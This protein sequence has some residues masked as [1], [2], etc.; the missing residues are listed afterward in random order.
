MTLLARLRATA[1]GRPGARPGSSGS[2]S[3]PST[4]SPPGSSEP[5]EHSGAAASRFG[6]TTSRRSVPRRLDL[7]H[8]E[9]LVAAASG[10][11][12]RPSRR[13]CRTRVSSPRETVAVVPPVSGTA[14][15]S[16]LTAEIVPWSSW[17]VVRPPSA[18]R[19][20]RTVAWTSR[21]RPQGG[22]G[23]RSS[24]S[25]WPARAVADWSAASRAS[26]SPR[27]PASTAGARDGR[28]RRS[29]SR[30][31]LRRARPRRRPG[32]GA[33]TAGIASRAE[34]DAPTS[35][36]S[37]VSVVR[38]GVR[39]A[40]DADDRASITARSAGAGKRTVSR[41]RCRARGGAPRRRALRRGAGAVLPTGRSGG[42][43][44]PRANHHAA[45][46]P[47]TTQLPLDPVRFG[48]DA[49]PLVEA[50][51]ADPARGERVDASPA[52]SVRRMSS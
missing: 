13:A 52:T 15:T 11:R 8:H 20:T 37:C 33:R 19:S 24:G 22:A 9:D 50:E 46:G 51:I 12:S 7:A 3:S 23:R 44:D 18:G 42:A 45:P 21:A 32:R 41:R 5:A 28:P 29:R 36:T 1:A 48:Q 17:I 14:A 34:G 35:W 25:G 39:A 43:V 26:R 31:R 4:G 27:R 38:P 10:R 6:T 2:S 47:A 16:A 49:G 30:S 40:A